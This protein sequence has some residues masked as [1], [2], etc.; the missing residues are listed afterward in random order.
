MSPTSLVPGADAVKSR[1]TRSGT[2]PASP[3]IVVVG[4][5]GLGWHGTRPSSRISART[6]SGPAA[7]SLRANT[8]CTLR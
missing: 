5:H 1:R 8:A 4:R 2:S 6:S 7:I 3:A